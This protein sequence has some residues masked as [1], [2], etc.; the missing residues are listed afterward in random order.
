MASQC[1]TDK[2]NSNAPHVCS[3]SRRLDKTFIKCAHHWYC[4]DAG[5]LRVVQLLK[6]V[7]CYHGH[8]DSFLVKAGS[9]VATLGLPDS[10]GVPSSSTGARRDA[11]PCSTGMVCSYH[12]SQA[13]YSAML[14]GYM[15]L[16]G[17][18]LRASMAMTVSY[19]H[20]HAKLHM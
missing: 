8:A 11:I 13:L 9:G 4:A 5:G 1:E 6:F 7:G 19:F 18:W 3:A 16:P 17:R 12:V 14:S 10:P 15:F 2:R 20:V